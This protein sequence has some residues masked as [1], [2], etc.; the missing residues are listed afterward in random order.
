MDY[1]ETGKKMEV[2]VK[3]GVPYT[4]EDIANAKKIHSGANS[5]N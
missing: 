3:L 2:M 1:S 5:K 4:E